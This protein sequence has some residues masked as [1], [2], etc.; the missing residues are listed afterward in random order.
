MSGYEVLIFCK[1]SNNKDKLPIGEKQMMNMKTDN[2]TINKQVQ[3][4]K[5]K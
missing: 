4:Q 2:L 1:S 3:R 5:D